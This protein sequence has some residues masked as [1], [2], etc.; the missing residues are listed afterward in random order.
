VGLA[1][2]H[3]SLYNHSYEANAGDEASSGQTK[4]SVVLRDIAAGDEIT[5]IH[6]GG[7]GDRSPVWF[8]VREPRETSRGRKQNGGSVGKRIESR[9]GRIVEA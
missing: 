6:N 3:G 1:L 7:P 9:P 2:G 4:V 5:I 8:K